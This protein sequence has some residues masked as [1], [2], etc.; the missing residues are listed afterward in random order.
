MKMA[1]RFQ[2]L[3]ISS[4]LRRTARRRLNTGALMKLDLAVDDQLMAYKTGFYDDPT[5][6]RCGRALAAGSVALDIGANVG[7]YSCALGMHLKSVGG[8]LYAFEPVPATFERLR[9]NL[10]LNE[11]GDVVTANRMALGTEAGELVLHREPGGATDNAV[12]DNMLSAEDRQNI[13]KAHWQAF[14]APM[15]RLDDW[16]EGQR[17]QRCDL[18]KI[19]VEGAEML[20]FEGGRGFVERTRPVVVGEFSP[21]WMRQIGQDFSEVRRYFEPL[22]YRFYREIEGRPRPLTEDLIAGGVEVPTY[23]LVPEDKIGLMQD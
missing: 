19:D 14:R 11:L 2:N 13:S 7:I 8:R 1:D 3:L 21:Y 9:E 12:G 5:I 16:A 20:V 17:I 22:G 4:G 18:I 15:E 10:E 6:L 23:W